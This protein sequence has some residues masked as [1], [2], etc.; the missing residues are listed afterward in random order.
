MLV[1]D[2]RDQQMF[3]GRILVPAAA[4]LPQCIMESLFEFASETRHLGLSPAPAEG[5]TGFDYNV[6]R[7]NAAIK[8]QV[9]RFQQIIAGTHGA[10]LHSGFLNSSSAAE[11]WVWTLLICA[12]T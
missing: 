3:K 6:I 2:Q 12:W 1:V 11:R 9:L 7:G 4:G 10:R 5:P 8:S